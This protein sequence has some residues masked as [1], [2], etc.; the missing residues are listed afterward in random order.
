M[1]ALRSLSAAAK[2]ATMRGTTYNKPLRTEI[3]A[4]KTFSIM[5][6]PIDRI[7]LA[8]FL[9]EKNVKRRL[10]QPITSQKLLVSFVFNFSKE[11]CNISRLDFSKPDLPPWN[12]YIASEGFN[13]QNYLKCLDI[14]YMAYE[15]LELQE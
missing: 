11:F 1:N 15:N 10:F 6:L 3:K 14:K 8:K 7:I 2:P 12:F 9:V 13:Y 4:Q 5:R